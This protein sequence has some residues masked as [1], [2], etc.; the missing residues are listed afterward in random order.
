M[1]LTGIAYFLNLHR[2]AVSPVT[3]RIVLE[4][5][6][7]VYFWP[8]ACVIL[9][10]KSLGTLEKHVV[11][12]VCKVV[13]FK[14]RSRHEKVLFMSERL[15]KAGF[16]LILMVKS[17]SI[18]QAKLLHDACLALQRTLLLFGVKLVE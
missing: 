12:V 2:F 7:F 14:L 9:E 5:Q 8:H 10:V 16:K 1:T 13:C 18:E 17:I 3:R 11:K 4:V 6:H 15:I